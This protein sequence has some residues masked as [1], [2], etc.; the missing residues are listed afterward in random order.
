[1]LCCATLR[2]LFPFYTHHNTINNTHIHKHKHINNRASGGLRGGRPLCCVFPF[3]TH[4]HTIHSYNLLTLLY[5]MYTFVTIHRQ[6]IGWL[7]SHEEDLSD[8]LSMSVLLAQ[9][10][11]SPAQVR[12]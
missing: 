6:G 11:R 4:T 5:H 12:D 1:M 9:P 8:F 10:P 2:S 3:Y 7:V